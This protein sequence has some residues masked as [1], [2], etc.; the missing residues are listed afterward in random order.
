[1][2]MMIVS[3]FGHLHSRAATQA[4]PTRVPWLAGG[5]AEDVTTDP[6]EVQNVTIYVEVDVYRA[7]QT[8]SAIAG[9]PEGKGQ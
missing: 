8:I 7:V 6:A 1:M 9:F 3:L 4:E 5:R 2:K